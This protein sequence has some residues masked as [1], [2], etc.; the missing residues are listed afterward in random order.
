MA[1]RVPQQ[2]KAARIRPI[3][4]QVTKPGHPSQLTRPD[5]HVAPDASWLLAHRLTTL[6]SLVAG[7]A[8]ETNNPITYLLGNL[9]E[10]ERLHVTLGETLAV[11]REA[12]R[13]LAPEQRDKVRA[14]ETKLQETGGLETGDD[15][16]RDALEGGMRIRDLVREL[17]A[18]SRPDSGETESLDVHTLLDFALRALKV[19]L[20][21][22]AEVVKEYEA[23]GRVRGERT[24]LGR[25]FLNLIQNAL[26][27]CTPIDPSRH[28]ITLRT[29]DV[30][31]GVEIQIE[32]TGPGISPDV[33]ERLFT[34][35]FSTKSEHGLGLG[36]FMSRRSIE[37]HS[38]SL[39][40]RD[41]EHGGTV[42]VVSIPG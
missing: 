26:Q 24:K 6:G 37:E 42:F 32:D 27:A 12:A 5:A 35:F 8:H 38:G 15:L 11:Y 14:A 9:H 17:L 16:V 25:V 30:E 13:T 21:E 18:L 29:R 19:E 20:R 2:L 28:V 36:L 3:R 10:L 41:G 1:R 33:R 31:R 23:R 39:T 7:V 4:Q 34:P 22:R 40:L